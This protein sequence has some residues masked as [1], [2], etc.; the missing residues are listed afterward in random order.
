MASGFDEA[1]R[2][3]LYNLKYTEL[4]HALY[5][6]DGVYPA[7]DSEESAFIH[8]EA[9]K[10]SSKSHIEEFKSNVPCTQSKTSA[11]PH[12]PRLTS[13]PWCVE[14]KSP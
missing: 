5:V 9:T 7:K 12:L 10:A 8:D 3:G 14:P 4:R 2:Q 11:S 6:S 13:T 1:I